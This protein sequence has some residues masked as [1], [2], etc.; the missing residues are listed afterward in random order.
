MSMKA[1]K[2]NKDLSSVWRILLTLVIQLAL[3]AAFYF[4]LP[5]LKTL[6]MFTGAMISFASLDV[7]L[8][9]IVFT[10]IRPSKVEAFQP[11]VNNDSVILTPAAPVF[12]PPPVINNTPPSSND[13]TVY[14]SNTELILPSA[15]P[16]EAIITGYLITENGAGQRI[17]INAPEFVIGRQ[18]NEVNYHIDNTHISR[19]H[20]V[21]IQKNNGFY[22]KD[23]E[24]KNKTYLNGYEIAPHQEFQ[25]SHN[26]EIKV[27][28]I[29]F[30]FEIIQS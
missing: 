2:Q 12:T 29:P 18:A 5:K 15:S 1:Q 24:S 25:L 26:D 17:Q 3:L 14:M 22:L 19:K 9:L 28:D 23:L 4:I 16:K 27:F 30:R 10:V 21:I 13:A 11:A 20:T 7:L 8:T 6:K